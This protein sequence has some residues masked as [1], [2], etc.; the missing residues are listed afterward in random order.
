MTLQLTK[1]FS[2]VRFSLLLY[3]GLILP[4]C[5]DAS[6][7][8]ENSASSESQDAGFEAVISGAFEGQVSGNGVLVFLPQ[9]GFDKQGYYFL[10]D[11]Q[12]VRAHGVT[13]ILPP[14]LTAGKH[15]LASPAPLDI[16]TVPSVRVDR[17]MGDSVASSDR[18]TTGFMDLTAFPNDVSEMSGA[19]VAGSFAFETEDAKGQV[20]AVKG[21]FSFK[22][23]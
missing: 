17:D 11:G 16:G 2:T 3:A 15:E 21:T 1:R 19:D 18:N 23:R 13:F 22:V 7:Q 4:S 14:G 9:G 20:I 12:G 5:D 10:A 6:T 8:A